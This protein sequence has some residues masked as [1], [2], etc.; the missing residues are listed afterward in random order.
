MS[1]KRG[2]GCNVDNPPNF[3]YHIYGSWLRKEEAMRH[4]SILTM[5]VLVLVATGQ[6]QFKSG[7]QTGKTGGDSFMKSDDSGLL[8]GWFD[9]NRLTMKQSY[10]L[11]YMTAGGQ[12]LS[13]G[14]YTNSLSYRISDPLTIRADVSL[15]HSPFNNLGNKLGSDL[16][17]IYLSRAQ[18]D[19][20]PS[21]NT[22]FQLQY[23]QLPA[24]YWL[25]ND[26]SWGM[27]GPDRLQE[28]SR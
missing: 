9:P 18:I 24:M 23:R 16:T 25:N 14:V 10:S 20:R 27:S 8:F 28:D 22:I 1:N 2:Q 11:S 3:G 15:M 4:S 17:G 12:S 5:L 26:R 6:A 21:E 7:A 13:L 19:Y